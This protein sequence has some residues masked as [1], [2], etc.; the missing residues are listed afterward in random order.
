VLLKK[1]YKS[2]VE[3]IIFSVLIYN[4]TNVNFLLEN[5]FNLITIN[6]VLVGFLFTIY[7]I[8]IPLLD[9]EIMEAYEKTKEI[10]RVFD[11]ITLGIVYGILSVLFTIMGLAIFGIV[12]ENKMTNIYKLWLT[13]DLSS[14]ILVMKS[15]LLSILDMSSIVGSIRDFNKLKRKKCQ[16]NDEMKNRFIKKG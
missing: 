13:I 8:L 4:L 6:T 16:A 10:E 7:T 9:E 11:N 5:E 2:I 3:L 12:T 1:Y 14:F 15:M